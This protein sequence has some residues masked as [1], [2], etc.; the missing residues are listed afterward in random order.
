MAEYVYQYTKPKTKITVGDKD[1]FKPKVKM[2]KFDDA[3]SFTLEITELGTFTSTVTAGKVKGVSVDKE[4]SIEYSQ[5]PINPDF[6]DE[7]G[8]DI[9]I[10]QGKVGL[11]NVLNFTY[12]NDHVVGYLQPPLTPEEI[13]EG[14]VRPDHIVNS[15][16]FYC[17]DYGG[18]QT[19]GGIEWKT[20]K[21]GH[22]YRMK[23]SSYDG[24]VDPVWCDWSISENVVSLTIPLAW[25]NN[26]KTKFPITIA[27]IGDTFGYGDIG[28][29]SGTQSANFCRGYKTS[30]P[31]VTG[32]ITS[33]SRYTKVS[34][35]TNTEGRGIYSDN[36][37]SPNTKLAVDSGNVTI[38]TTAG[39]FTAN[40][41]YDFAAST[42]YW[43]AWFFGGTG[44]NNLYYDTVGSNT[45]ASVS[46]TF[47]TWP[48]PF[49]ASPSAGRNVSI[50]CTYTPTASGWTHKLLGVANASTGKINGISL[51]SISKVNGI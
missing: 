26:T 16:A 49:G 33:I 19:V 3:H 28:G 44:D 21:V 9:V 32:S 24:K 25:W 39:W 10:T 11:S 50:Y 27:P 2:D 34:A 4:F 42:T 47:E 45:Y 12:S 36:A 23:A 35:F 13:A 31:A 20:G 22:L 43:L 14:S 51:A 17:T 38:T 48:D 1:T 8:L 41:A 30:S 29:S 5:T 37:G 15:I 7:G 40:V 46:A 6:N 18:M